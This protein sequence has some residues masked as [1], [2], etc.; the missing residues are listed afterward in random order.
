MIKMIIALVVLG[1]VWLVATPWDWIGRILRWATV[2]AC[3]W[4][5]LDAETLRTIPWYDKRS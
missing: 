4:G 3:E 1:I 2:K 5:G